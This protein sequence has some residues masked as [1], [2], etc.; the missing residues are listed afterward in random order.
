MFC[1]S[2]ADLAVGDKVIDGSVEYTIQS[3]A[4]YDDIG[5]ANAHLEVVLMKGE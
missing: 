5:G 3:I 1:G 2:S 4:N